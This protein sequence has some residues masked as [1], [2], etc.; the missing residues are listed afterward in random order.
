MKL[1]TLLRLGDASA[2]DASFKKL[3]DMGFRA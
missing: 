3:F 2:A 1:G